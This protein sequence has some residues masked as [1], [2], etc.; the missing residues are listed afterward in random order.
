MGREVIIVCMRNQGPL[1][2]PLRI[3]PQIHLREINSPIFRF[4]DPV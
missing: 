3:H 2:R 1:L 4:H